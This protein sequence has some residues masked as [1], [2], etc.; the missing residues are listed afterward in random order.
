MSVN[1][2]FKNIYHDLYYDVY[3]AVGG[4][5]ED[6]AVNWPLYLS[7]LASTG[8][9]IMV[10]LA[11]LGVVYR[12]SLLLINSARFIAKDSK[13]SQSLRLIARLMWLFSS[14]LAVMSQL[15]FEPETVKATA[16][17]GIWSVI[18]YMAWYNLGYLMQKMLKNYGLNASIEQLLHNLL[19]MLIIVLWIASVMSQ[20]GFDIVSVVAG[21]G[22]AGI[23][24]GFAAQATLANFIAGITILIEQSFQVG[25]WVS[26]N[27]KEGKVVQIALRTTQILTRDNITVIFPN[28][29]VAS[30]EVINLTAKNLIRFDIEVRI[31][32][33]ADIESA[34]AIIL[35]ILANTKEVL[36]RPAPTA[37]VDK[38][39]DFG[40]FFIVRFW[41]NP[42]H[43]SRMPFI[44][45]NLREQIKVALDDAS[46]ATPYPHMQ[47]LMPSAMPNEVAPSVK[48]SP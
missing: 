15:N 8:I 22:I 37:T 21:L 27:E 3:K 10:L 47:L 36:E 38:I 20:F 33:E 16:K 24:V 25:D 1:Q 46:I 44:K 4:S 32:L 28:S 30:A 14:L 6:E 35:D 11:I 2:F 40:V 13:Y 23:A 19:S 48:T 5:L 41:V 31:A 9:K 39:G 45:E 26:I 42:P 7:K 43:V 17:A 18:F 12:L 29:T 34:R